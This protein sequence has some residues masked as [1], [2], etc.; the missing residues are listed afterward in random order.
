M[1]HNDP[2]YPILSDFHGRQE[3]RIES[4]V[5]LTN[6]LSLCLLIYFSSFFRLS[7][8]SL[9]PEEIIN[10]TEPLQ[11]GNQ[12]ILYQST[13]S[14]NSSQI[15]SYFSYLQPHFLVF[16]FVSRLSNMT[17]MDITIVIMTQM[18]QNLVYHAAPF[19]EKKIVDSAGQVSYAS[20]FLGCK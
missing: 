6:I 19:Q 11:V 4:V 10:N 1:F 16:L 9:L 14:S 12:I 17:Y 20:Q 3:S 2:K 15:F 5:S 13:F 8:L 7:R 18:N